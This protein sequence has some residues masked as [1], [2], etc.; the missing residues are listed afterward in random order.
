[1]LQFVLLFLSFA[2]VGCSIGTSCFA[3]DSHSVTTSGFPLT[4]CQAHP[5][6][7][8]APMPIPAPP[9]M[10]LHIVC[11]MQTQQLCQSH[12]LHNLSA[13]LWNQ[14][15][16]LPMFQDNRI[17]SGDAQANAKSKGVI[18]CEVQ[19]QYCNG[20][21][22][23]ATMR[24]INDWRSQVQSGAKMSK[25]FLAVADDTTVAHVTVA[26][27]YFF[28]HIHILHCQITTITILQCLKCEIFSSKHL[29]IGTKNLVHYDTIKMSDIDI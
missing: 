5:C 24:K 2:S 10:P 20:I 13:E 4:I 8:P 9:P 25:S 6:T 28:H 1:M 23:I 16:D 26:D 3:S 15:I 21:M 14:T 17:N 27:V 18:K 22:R 29:T 19:T 7:C 11:I 12:C